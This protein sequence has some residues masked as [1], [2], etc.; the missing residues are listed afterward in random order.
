LRDAGFEPAVTWSRG[1]LAV[2]AA[3]PRG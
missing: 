3:D 2:F 1:D